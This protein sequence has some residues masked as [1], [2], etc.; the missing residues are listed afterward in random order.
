LYYLLTGKPPFYRSSLIKTLVAHRVDEIPL[1]TD[2]CPDFPKRIDK[3][4]QRMVAKNPEERYSTMA[5]VIRQLKKF[6]DDT[7]FEIVETA[8]GLGGDDDDESDTQVFDPKDLASLE[9]RSS[10]KAPRPDAAPS[11]NFK[12]ATFD[13]SATLSGELLDDGSAIRGD[14]IQEA[15]TAVGIDLGTTFSAIAYLDDSGRPQTLVN[16]EGDKTTP[17]SVLFEGDDVIV[18]KEA[19][20]A[21]ATDMEFVAQCAKRELG[22]T[23][24][25]QSIAGKKYPPEVI[26]AWILKKLR[27]DAET[28]IGAITDAVVTVPAY[29]DEVRRRATQRAGHIAGLNVIDII[30]E[31]TAA[32]VAYGYQQGILQS[33]KEPTDSGPEAAKSKILVYDLGGGTFD[34]TVMEI[35]GSKFVA[36]ATDGD[37][38]LGGRDWDQR[39]VDFV[40]E[41]FAEQ[42]EMDPRQDKN[43]LGRLLRECEDSKHTLSSRQ[44]THVAFD[45]KGQAIRV[46]IT[47]ELFESLTEDLLARTEFTTRETL[48]AAEIS[49]DQLDRILLVGGSTRMPSVADLLKSISGISPDRSVSPDEA[50][51]HGAALL[52]GMLLDANQSSSPMFEVLNVNSHSLGVVGMNPKTRKPQSAILIKRNSTLPIKT[53]RSFRTKKANQSSILVRVVEGESR[54]PDEC[55][56]MGKCIIRNLPENLPVNTQFDVIFEYEENGLLTV[57]VKL[58]DLEMTQTVTRENELGPDDLVKWQKLVI[59]DEAKRAFENGDGDR[60]K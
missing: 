24:F 45:Y 49:W 50:V 47:R 22:E 55:S 59:G 19:I 43:A 32:A 40:A 38:R 9:I 36:L 60:W 5:D 15:K 11:K 16:A 56:Q 17:S 34:V 53:K 20:K 10:S 58:D 7:D 54:D 33:D 13:R 52:A 25:H 44:K 21:M 3:I 30:N 31:P 41:R 39:L 48:K 27:R 37:V 12:T 18:G 2:S 28:Q 29:F 46:E 42:H 57:K 1:I 6:D 51:A 23:Y 14:S 8:G 4:F 35:Q 26:L